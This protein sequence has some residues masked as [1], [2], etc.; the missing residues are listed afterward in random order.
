MSEKN[1]KNVKN[2]DI[3]NKNTKKKKSRKIKKSTIKKISAIIVLIAILAVTLYFAFETLKPEKAAALVNGEVI[4]GQELEKEYNQ[5]PDLYK[6]LITKEEFLDQIINVKLLL[7]E[8]ESHAIVVTEDEIIQELDYIKRQSPTEEAFEQLLSQRDTTLD[9]LKEQI[10]EQLTINKLLDETVLSKIEVSDSK[11]KTFYQENQ[12][13]FKAKEGEIRARHILVNTEEQAEQ[14]LEDLQKGGD[15]AEIAELNSID[16]VSAERGGDL[17]FI[18]KGQLVKEFEDA[19]FSLKVGELS[20]IVKTQFGYHIIKRESDMLQ[21]SEAKEQIRQMLINDISN[22]AIEIYINQLKSDSTIIKGGVEITTKGETFTE[23]E[24]KICKEDGKL[25]IRLFS[26][27]KNSASNW[28]SETFDS[29]AVSR[30]ATDIV[31][32]H[33]QLDTGDN[34]LTDIKEKGIPKSELE[35][36]QKYNSKSTVPTYVFGCR[37]IRIGNA[38]ESLEEEKTE[39]KL[40]IEKLISENE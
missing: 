8:A 29:L 13:D 11:I 7:Q 1:K 2:E 6:S 24:D 25:I 35:I 34:T 36:F 14:L 20:T 21:Y 19:A 39:F 16:A 15:F 40:V 26:T 9:E 5:L 33:W 3:L 27:T 18:R 22:N 17:A 31:V 23:T 37:Y 28:I 10:I 12:D 4:T 32:Y 38:Y 30:Y